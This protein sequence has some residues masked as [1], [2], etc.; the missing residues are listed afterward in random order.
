MDVVELA[1]PGAWMF[2][3]RQL[4]DD[5]GVFLEW[6]KAE[7]FTKHVGHPLTAAQ[8]NQSVSRRGTLRGIHYADVPPGQAK[9][10]SCA[11]GAVLDIIVDLRVG[12]ATFGTHA[13]VRLD[14]VDRRAVYL[15]EGLGH[16]FVAL[17][18]DSVVSYL[19]STPY[20][21]NAEHGV[22]PLDPELALP[23]PDDLAPV[24]SAKDAA[25]PTLAAARTAG[26]L[27]SNAACE[28]RGAQL[29]SPA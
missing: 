25:A 5:R 15:S 10:V 12:S 4:R 7:L 16:A 6:F 9:Y 19:V 21:P 29:R 11:R 1:V 2:T 8:A 27:P 14:D 22:H 20:D 24:L 26:A 18:D 23:W 28:E 17:E 3:P 13:A